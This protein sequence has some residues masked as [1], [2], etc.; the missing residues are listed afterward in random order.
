MPAV[1]GI[2][3]PTKALCV[4][5]FGTEEGSDFEIPAQ[6]FNLIIGA[7]VEFRFLSS[8]HRKQDAVGDLIEDWEGKQIEE[9]APL[10]TVLTAEGQKGSVLPVRLCG[11]VTEVGTLELWCVG[12]N[13]AGR[14]KLEF[15]VR[16]RTNG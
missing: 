8:T 9:L 15:N 5:P 16:D 11:K 10:Q 1:P 2:A 4:V 7:P 6:E 14:W 12:R 13:D 3:P